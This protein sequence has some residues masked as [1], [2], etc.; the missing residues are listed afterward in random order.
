MIETIRLAC[1]CK[2]ATQAQSATTMKA[3]GGDDAEIILV[4][5]RGGIGV[6]AIRLA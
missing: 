4:G 3:E 1:A 2:D 6:P 5:G